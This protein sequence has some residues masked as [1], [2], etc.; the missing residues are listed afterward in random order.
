[1]AV[2]SHFLNICSGQ[3]GHWGALEIN[4]KK[5]V[6]IHLIP[7]CGVLLPA[8]LTQPQP[9]M[10]AAKPKFPSSPKCFACGKSVYAAEEKKVRMRQKGA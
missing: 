3:F 6:E 7:G 8:V 5:G 2:S 10:S 9:E 4:S 1:M